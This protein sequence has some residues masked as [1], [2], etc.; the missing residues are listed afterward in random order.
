MRRD[1]SV[2][3]FEREREAFMEKRY[4]ENENALVVS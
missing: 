4:R 2:D 1:R 3:A